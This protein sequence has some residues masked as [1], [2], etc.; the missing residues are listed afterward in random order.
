MVGI[1]EVP[2]GA[3]HPQIS[4][5]GVGRVDLPR[6]EVRHPRSADLEG[7]VYPV[8]VGIEVLYTAEAVQSGL[9][10]P[11]F[12]VWDVVVRDDQPVP[13]EL[14]QVSAPQ[15]AYPYDVLGAG[16]YALYRFLGDLLLEPDGV[17]LAHPVQGHVGD[18]PGGYAVGV[19]VG[20][21]AHALRIAEDVRGHA[22]VPVETAEV[23]RRI[24]HAP[25]PVCRRSCR[26]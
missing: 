8:R 12:R 9:L 2:H 13:V 5:V 20:D 22:E 10:P 18:R 15:V 24:P 11:P 21:D 7:A 3:D 26:R 1:L 23:T 25:S 6:Q 16:V 14:G 19:D 4:K 17:L